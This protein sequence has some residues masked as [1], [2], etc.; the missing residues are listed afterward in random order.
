MR[1]LKIKRIILTVI[2]SA[3]MVTGLSGCSVLSL[4]NSFDASKYVLGL[5]DAYYKGV[6]ENYL[7]QTEDTQENAQKVYDDVMKA[8]AE[9][10]AA[11][12]GVGMNE[13]SE[14]VFNEFA[15]KIYSQVKY[16]VKEAVKTKE[17]FTVDIVIS[18]ILVLESIEEQYNKYLED[19]NARNDAFEFSD[20]TDE[21]YDKEF[22]R[23]VLEIFKNNQDNIQY[24]EDVTVTVSVVLEGKTY[25]VSEADIMKIDEKVLKAD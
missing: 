13:D 24:G 1:N 18:P 4:F 17:G 11:Y 7:D 15:K 21:E 23:G 19:F 6:F 10:F 12:A 20:W 9:A 8:K 16:E 3:L 22:E 25:N 14:P 2:I 5:M